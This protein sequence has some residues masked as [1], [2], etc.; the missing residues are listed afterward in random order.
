MASRVDHVT[1][2]LDVYTEFAGRRDVVIEF[3]PT[4]ADD[5]LMKLVHEKWR[6]QDEA[7]IAALVA[8]K[9]P[10]TNYFL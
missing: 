9:D 6:Q 10:L 7:R 4:E 1:L 8:S 5:A 3:A 2:T